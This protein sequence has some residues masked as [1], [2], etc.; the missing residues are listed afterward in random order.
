MITWLMVAAE[1]REFEGVLK[2]ASSVR[3]LDWPGAAFSREAA[4]G[5]SRWFLVANGPGPRLVERALARKPEVDRVLSVGFCGA[6]D[7]AL[8]IGDIVV[9][10][11]VPQGLGASFVRGD[12]V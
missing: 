7:P 1:G 4:C 9:S 11:E 6:L 3:P 12:V 5:H 8:Q 10:G 2:R